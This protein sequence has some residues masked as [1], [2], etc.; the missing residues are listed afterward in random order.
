MYHIGILTLL[1][2]C[3]QEDAAEGAAEVCAGRGMPVDQARVCAAALASCQEIFARFKLTEEK[4]MQVLIRF[5][6]YTP[7]Y[8][9]EYSLYTPCSLYDMWVGMILCA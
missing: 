8:I 5:D 9:L 7:I 2:F 1:Y 3:F 6:S 4:A